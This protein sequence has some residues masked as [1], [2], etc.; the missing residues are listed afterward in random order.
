MYNL[1][2]EYTGHTYNTRITDTMKLKIQ[3]Q[4]YESLRYFETRT[5]ET[6]RLITRTSNILTTVIDE[7]SRSLASTIATPTFHRLAKSKEINSTDPTVE[8]SLLV[9][10]RHGVFRIVSS[11]RDRLYFSSQQVAPNNTQLKICH[12]RALTSNRNSGSFTRII[13]I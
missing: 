7:N 13:R 11:S 6:I 5:S 9:L 4:R 10:Q 1:T 3:P 12:L 8:V 2:G